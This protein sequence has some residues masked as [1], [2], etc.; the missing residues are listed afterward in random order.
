MHS[1]EPLV[2]FLVQRIQSKGLTSLRSPENV[3]KAPAVSF[4]SVRSSR[5]PASFQ[6][7]CLCFQGI[8][9]EDRTRSL[10]IG[11]SLIKYQINGNSN[12]T[13]KCL[14]ARNTFH[15][16]SHNNASALES[17][18]ST[19]DDVVLESTGAQNTVQKV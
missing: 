9:K 6:R 12:T 8:L 10:A 1:E 16:K 5:R 2:L 18:A 13:K 11:P 3:C 14:L 17:S 19:E 4:I 7:A 15:N